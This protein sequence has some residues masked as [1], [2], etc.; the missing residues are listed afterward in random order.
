[1]P[2]VNKTKTEIKMKRVA[3]IV[4]FDVPSHVRVSEL[5]ADVRDAVEFLE[6]GRDEDSSVFDQVRVKRVTVKP[7]PKKDV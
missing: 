4:A 6:Y 2:R 5:R 3:M 1:M 7:L